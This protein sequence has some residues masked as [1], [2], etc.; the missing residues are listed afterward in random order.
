MF[1][2]DAQY[3][4]LTMDTWKNQPPNFTDPKDLFT[5][6]LDVINTYVLDQADENLDVVLPVW[7][8]ISTGPESFVH[9]DWPIPVDLSYSDP[10][11]QTA[12]LAKFPLGDL[13][14]FP[15]EK[16]QWLAQRPA[17]YDSIENAL[18]SGRLVTSIKDR[19]RLPVGF[20]FQQNYPNPFNPNTTITFSI[21]KAGHI[22]LKVFNILGQEVAT[23]TDDFMTPETYKIEFDGSRLASGIYI[24]KIRSGG[25]SKSIK[26]VLLK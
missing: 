16:E 9:P 21:P 12:G 10:G 6:Q 23:L 15:A 14:W 24:A 3:P 22:S 25:S 20:E 1:D 4:F 19:N 5:T 11:L 26:M 18:N 13:N 17:E 2:N 7:R 8:L